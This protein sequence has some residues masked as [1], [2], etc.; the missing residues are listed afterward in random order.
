MVA[1]VT[2]LKVKGGGDGGGG[3]AV[4]KYLIDGLDYAEDL[5]AAYYGARSQPTEWIGD[6]AGEFELAGEPVDIDV[7]ADA[8]DGV[9]PSGE[10]PAQMQGGARG[11]VV[12]VRT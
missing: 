10:K 5:A 12:L 2:H 3:A 11:H 4:G 1:K 8:L 9:L 7:L 6:L